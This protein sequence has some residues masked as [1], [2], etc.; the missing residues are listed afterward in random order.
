MCSSVEREDPKCEYVKTKKDMLRWAELRANVG[1]LNRAFLKTKN[2][3]SRWQ[4]FLAINE[5]PICKWSKADGAGLAFPEL[6][7]KM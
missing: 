1:G 2:V 3:D 6:R 4:G 7:I 5:K